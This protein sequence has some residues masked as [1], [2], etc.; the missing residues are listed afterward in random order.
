MISPYSFQCAGK[1]LRVNGRGLK[2][3]GCEKLL[4]MEHEGNE[5]SAEG[6]ERAFSFPNNHLELQSSNRG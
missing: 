5:K 4:F 2:K 3:V 6:E 1:F